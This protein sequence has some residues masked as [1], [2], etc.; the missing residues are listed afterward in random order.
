MCGTAVKGQYIK[1]KI[2]NEQVKGFKSFNLHAASIL[3][4]RRR[5]EVAR[6]LKSFKYFKTM[7]V[8]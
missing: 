5:V 2:Q 8:K 6:R 3:L 4:W 1:L 7:A